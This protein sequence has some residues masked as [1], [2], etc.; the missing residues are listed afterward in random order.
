MSKFEEYDWDELP[1]EAKSAALLLGYTKEIWDAD[2]EP[3][4]CDVF[5]KELSSEQQSAATFLGYDQQSWDS[6]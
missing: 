6:S 5:W 2:E 3:D 4:E 1:E